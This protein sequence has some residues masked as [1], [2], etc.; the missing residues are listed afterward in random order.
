M[1]TV[2]FDLG[3]VLIHVHLPKLLSGL[4]NLSGLSR[5][6][7]QAFLK[8][9]NIRERYET[10]K[11]STIEFYTMIQKRAKRGFSVKE[12]EEAF[13]NIFTPKTDVWPIVES[14]KKEKVKLV[15]LSNTSECHFEYSKKH[16]PILE[17]FDDFVL[18][19]KVGAWKPDAEIFETALKKANCSSENCFYTDDIPEFIESAKHIGLPG[20]VFKDA[21]TL[22]IDLLKRKFL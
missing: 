13:S 21:E 19:Y 8:D 9:K 12:F 15:L 20:A 17:L 3:N 18:S 5:E 4:E 6:E 22:H 16:Y 14:L 11:I 2:F 1:K 10:G 7:L